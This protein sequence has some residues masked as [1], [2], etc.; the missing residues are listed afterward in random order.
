MFKRIF[1]KG[2]KKSD[3]QVNKEIQQIE[4]GEIKDI[5][6][7]LKPGDWVGIKAGLL[8]QTLIGNKENPTLV[9]GFGYSTATNFIFMSPAHLEG[10][11]PQE[12]LQT[13]YNN[14]ASLPPDF[15]PNISNGIL[16]ASG[17]DFSSE[18]ILIPEKMQIA[19]ELLDAKE[20]LVSIPR[21]T[22]MMC[23]NKLTD[24][25]T[26]KKFLILH[27]HAWKDDSYGNAPIVNG[28][29]HLVDGQMVGYIP[30]TQEA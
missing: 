11:N 16:T 25:E 13:A 26:L 1:G 23:C 2:N 12:V 20:I 15:S 5:F 18:K 14:L 29:F 9:A 6:P 30:M 8:T 17:N 21:R 4:K 24:K 19:H 28:L 27:E 3:E 22:C 7:I 10:K